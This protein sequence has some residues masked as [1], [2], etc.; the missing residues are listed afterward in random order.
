MENSGASSFALAAVRGRNMIGKLYP[1]T[2]DI[3]TV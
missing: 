2:L 1:G 3:Y